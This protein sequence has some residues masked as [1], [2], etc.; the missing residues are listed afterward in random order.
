MAVRFVLLVA[1]A[2]ASELKVTQYEGPTECEEA[3]KVKVGDQLGMHYTGTIDQTSATGEK[4]KQF[5]SSRDRGQVQCSAA[6]N[7]E[8]AISVLNGYLTYDGRAEQH[9]SRDCEVVLILG[10]GAFLAEL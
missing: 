1:V 5:D 3:D 8:L 4:G 9:G 7:R 6:R 10:Q 2:A